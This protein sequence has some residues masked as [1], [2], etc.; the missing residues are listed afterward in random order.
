MKETLHCEGDSEEFF[1]N[2]FFAVYQQKRRWASSSDLLKL[3]ILSDNKGQRTKEKG[4]LYFA[5]ALMLHRG[6]REQY[7]YEYYIILSIP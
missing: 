1:L 3:L 2:L 4:L 5:N 6:V 7:K